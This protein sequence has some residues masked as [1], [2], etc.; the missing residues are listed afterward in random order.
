[1][2]PA[3]PLV[4]PLLVPAPPALAVVLPLTALVAEVAVAVALPPPVP[5]PVVA[6][7][8]ALLTIAASVAA[9]VV[10]LGLLAP[11]SV[12]IAQSVPHCCVPPAPGVDVPVP[13]GSDEL[14]PGVSTAAMSAARPHI[15]PTFGERARIPSLSFPCGIG[16]RGLSTH[17][18][19]RASVSD[20]TVFRTEPD[21]AAPLECPRAQAGGVQ[22]SRT[23]C[24][25][26][27]ITRSRGSLGGCAALCVSMRCLNSS[28]S[29]RSR[30]SVDT[31]SSRS[32]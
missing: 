9:P 26:Y 6:L 16:A 29:L 32:G 7:L 15:W 1:M 17:R 14:Q 8:V 21:L 19:G 30:A 18:R 22:P 27:T 5:T 4:V 31:A 11:V 12:V 23:H 2:L 3:P 10:P 25:T 13:A 28:I 24:P 20:C